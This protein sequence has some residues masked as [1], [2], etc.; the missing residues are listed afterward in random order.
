MYGNLVNP[1]PKPKKCHQLLPY[2]RHSP[3]K[4]IPNLS[5]NQHRRP[6]IN[7]STMPL[8]KKA[9]ATTNPLRTI[10]PRRNSSPPINEDFKHGVIEECVYLECFFDLNAF[11][12]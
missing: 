2:H 11:F 4:S 7:N 10:N 5:L 9:Y 8:S 12:V 1:F 6:F 3:P